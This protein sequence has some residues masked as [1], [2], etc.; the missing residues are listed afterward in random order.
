MILYGSVARVCCEIEISGVI[1]FGLL[2]SELGSDFVA[3][4]NFLRDEVFCTFKAVSSA[5][6]VEDSD[7]A[8]DSNYRSVVFFVLLTSGL[9]SRL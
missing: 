4:A 3:L 6:F 2:F 1:I 5:I 9:I 8:C 7:I